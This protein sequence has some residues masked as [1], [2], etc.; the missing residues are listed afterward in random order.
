VVAGG[1][2][3]DNE[4]LGHINGTVGTLAFI[5]GA[6][7]GGLFTLALVLNLPHL[8]YF[9]SPG[10]TRRTRATR[11][12]AWSPTLWAAR[13]TASPQ[14]SGRTRTTAPRSPST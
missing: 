7:P 6:F 11:P 3:L 2:G 9:S 5:A 14:R 8:T 10:A 12:G 1:L 13:R 4:S